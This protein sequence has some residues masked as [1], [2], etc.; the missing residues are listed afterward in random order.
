MRFK[1]ERPT[2]D[3]IIIRLPLRIGISFQPP[4]WSFM[5]GFEFVETAFIGWHFGPCSGEIWRD[6]S[7]EELAAMAE[8][9]W[10]DDEALGVSNA[11]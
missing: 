10:R 11:G 2:G 3:D 4:W 8:T 5:F 6:Y 7:D 9:E 1:I